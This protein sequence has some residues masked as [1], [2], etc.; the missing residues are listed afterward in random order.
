MRKATTSLLALVTAGLLAGCDQGPDQATVVAYAAS[1]QPADPALAEIYQRSC[2]ACHS[3]GTSDAPLVGDETAW[4]P[5]LEQGMDTLLTHVVEG[6]GGMPPYGLCMD[7]N[8]A[9]FEQLIQF[10]SHYPDNS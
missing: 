8:A 1:A 4:Q 5:R 2:Q 9:E 10:M 7:C 6:Y 3:R